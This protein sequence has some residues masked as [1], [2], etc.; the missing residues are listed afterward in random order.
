MQ[1]LLTN[2][3]GPFGAGL[4]PMRSALQ[5]LGRVTVLCPERERSGVSHSITYL[6]PVRTETIRLRDGSRARTLTGAPVDC[7]KFAL[8]EVFDEAPDLVVSGINLGLNL[9]VDLFYS[10]TVAAALEGALYG[11]RS[12]AFSTH[13]QNAERMENVAGQALRVLRRLRKVECG[14]RAF[15]VNIPPLPGPGVDPPIRVTSQS[16]AFP[17][18]E[19]VRS[20]GPRGRE[21]YFLDSTTGA[22][23]APEGSDVAALEAGAISVTPIRTSL[24][25]EEAA[26]RL[27]DALSDI[28]AGTRE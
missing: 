20:A 16:C 4:C 10:G 8:L 28:V 12:V 19:F 25:D 5:E 7:V 27:G 17:P 3:D 2:D 13:R 21:H 15:N 9:G 14:A 18:G 24:T 11:V 22:G 1:I 23:P 26:G 6:V